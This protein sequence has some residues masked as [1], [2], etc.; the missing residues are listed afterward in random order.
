[1]SRVTLTYYLIFFNRVIF[2]SRRFPHLKLQM[3]QM[4]KMFFQIILGH[5]SRFLR[6]FN[7]FPPFFLVRECSRYEDPLHFRHYLTRGGLLSLHLKR[8][9]NTCT[10]HR[11]C[12]RYYSWEGTHI[13]S[14]TWSKMSRLTQSLCQSDCMGTFGWRWWKWQMLKIKKIEQLRWYLLRL[15]DN[16]L[17]C[18]KYVLWCFPWNYDPYME[19]DNGRWL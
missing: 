3:Q 14:H 16:D 11:T 12:T 8:W 13:F 2:V 6:F 5:D 4:W 9:S 15:N 7:I 1:M 19:E 17:L 18:D 10:V